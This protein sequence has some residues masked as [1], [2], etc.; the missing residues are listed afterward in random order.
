MAF[1]TIHQD[2]LIPAFRLLWTVCSPQ[3]PMFITSESSSFSLF[4]A[5]SSK[6]FK[7]TLGPSQEI[8]KKL[9]LSSSLI[10]DMKASWISVAEAPSSNEESKYLVSTSSS[11]QNLIRMS[12][13]PL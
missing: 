9:F 3:V 12:I 13:C 11:S 1:P 2:D 10:P 8:C 6:T 5:I 7:F 4:S